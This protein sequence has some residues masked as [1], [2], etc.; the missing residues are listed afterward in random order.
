MTQQVLQASTDKSQIGDNATSEDALL[1]VSE[2][3]RR[4]RVDATTVRRWI[5]QGSLHAIALPH[6][7][8]RQVYRIRQRTL[9]EL[10][11]PVTS[12][13]E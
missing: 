3:A 2:V 9:D 8:K 11:H 5:S 4:L 13:E 7:G 6:Q 12:S 1:T 10:L